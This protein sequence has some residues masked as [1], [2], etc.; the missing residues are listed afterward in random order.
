MV[1]TI[2]V[3]QSNLLVLKIQGNHER[4]EESVLEMEV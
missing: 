4:C 2:I 1:L 3:L